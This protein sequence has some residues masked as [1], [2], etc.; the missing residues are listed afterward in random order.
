MHIEG[1]KNQQIRKN[2]LHTNSLA[3]GARSL[4]ASVGEKITDK[5]LKIL[6]AA[7]ASITAATIALSKKGKAKEATGDL[8]TSAFVSS[9]ATDKDLEEIHKIDLEAFSENYDIYTDFEEY[10]R[11]IEE[12]NVTTYVIKSADGKVVGYYQLEPVEDGELYIYSMGV[13][14]DLRATRASVAILDRIRTEIIDTAVEQEIKTVALDVYAENKPLVKLYKKFGFE[15]VDTVMVPKEEGMRCDHHMEIDVKKYLAEQAPETTKK[16]PEIDYSQMSDEQLEEIASQIRQNPI[17][18]VEIPNAIINKYTIPLILKIIEN[19]EKIVN[20]VKRLDINHIISVSAKNEETAKTKLAL[21]ERFLNDDNYKR[22]ELSNLLD[23][24]LWNVDRLSQ[25]EA[26]D[27]VLKNDDL[28]QEVALRNMVLASLSVNNEK[29]LEVFTRILDD[30]ELRKNPVVMSNITPIVQYTRDGFDVDSI[31]KSLKNENITNSKEQLNVFLD[32]ISSGYLKEQFDFIYKIMADERLCNIE[33]LKFYGVS[34]VQTL[35]SERARIARGKF[36]EKYL[37]DGKYYNNEILKKSILD[38]LYHINEIDNV[39]AKIHMIDTILFDKRFSENESIMNSFSSIINNTEKVYDAVA[40]AGIIKKIYSD[41]RIA[42]NK[43]VIRYLAQIIDSTKTESK[44]KADVQIIDNILSDEK[45]LNDP[46]VEKCLG[47]ILAADKREA[48]SKEQIKTLLK[49]FKAAFEKKHILKSAGEDI[50]DDKICDIFA[51]AF[52]ELLR[53]VEI[54]G[55]NNL[56]H[57]YNMKLIGMVEYARTI[58]ILK[59]Y[60]SYEKLASKINPEVTSEYIL[61]SKAVTELKKQY[62]AVKASGNVVKLKE[63]E[64]EI[65]T[66][67]REMREISSRKVKLDPQ[68]VINKT[69][70]LAAIAARNPFALNDFVD[71]IQD[72]TKEN[73]AIWKEK[74]NKFIFENLEIEYDEKVSRRLNLTASNYLGEIL[75]ANYSFK[76]GFKK[77]VELIKANPTKLNE[78]IFDKLPQNIKTKEM[79]EALGINYKKWS[80]VDKTSSVKIEVKL[81][82]EEARKAA[83]EAL[84]KEFNHPVFLELPIEETDKIFEALKAIDVEVRELKEPVWNENGLQ[85]GTQEVTRLFKGGQPIKFEDLSLIMKTIK[86]ELNN[87]D[88]WTVSTRDARLNSYKDTMY[89]HFMKDRDQQYHTARDLKE[90]TTVTL[91]IRKTDMNNI[92]HALFLGN[93]GACCTAVGTGCNQFSA[94]TYIMNKMISAIEIV[95]NGNFVGNTMCYIALVDGVPSLVLDNIELKADYH[96]NDKIRDALIEYAE[97]LCAEIGK[98]DMPIYAGPYRHKLKMEVFEANEHNMQIVG[99]SGEDEIYLDF[100]TNGREV[101][102]EEIDQVTLFKIR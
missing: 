42:D 45:I 1:L 4:T 31:I 95:D 22:E 86:E 89:T 14:E 33:F 87:N 92:S 81:S 68:Q 98:P 38:I 13:R 96:N 77:I 64:R 41:E 56:I 34:F 61:L 79:F 74:V 73:E 102:G 12:Q 2:E 54:I 70:V 53:A 49:L 11:D 28:C 7:A 27:R 8:N 76:N 6:G 62:P 51:L 29:K 5:A 10:K 3:F 24:M 55:E 32:L 21:I 90:D 18:Q 52:P 84:E 50:S 67:T 94:P 101:T 47:S 48:Y 59:N 15:I 26:L 66:Y 91:E 36:I 97:K 69:R 85:V 23:Y 75:S 19:P 30:K 93:H 83:I 71:L 43:S 80:T 88:F 35:S 25:V 58:W 100:I 44:F 9:I 78:E 46:T 40:K 63:L 65:A 72:G 16:Q 99:S 60:G 17:F 57:S 37:S 82:V 20:L 39:P